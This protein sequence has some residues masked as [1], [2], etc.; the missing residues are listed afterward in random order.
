MRQTRTTARESQSAAVMA[1]GDSAGQKCA[2][3]GGIDVV[4][5]KSAADAAHE[6][7]SKSPA[8]HYLVLR[9]Q[10]QQDIDI[11]D[12]VGQLL[13]MGRQADRRKM[14]FGAL[15]VGGFAQ[16]FARLEVERHH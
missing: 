2:H 1:S 7:E 14:S 15:G 4:F 11:R 10:I 13:E 3:F 9:E 8:L 16:S 12:F 5:D 6:N